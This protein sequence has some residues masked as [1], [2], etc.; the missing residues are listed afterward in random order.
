MSTPQVATED[1]VWLRSARVNFED[2][3][4]CINGK[5][6]SLDRNNPKLRLQAR[7]AFVIDLSK[8]EFTVQ[9]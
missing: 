4:L 1:A 2:N 7:A 3:V 9:E 6:G 8:V 5:Q